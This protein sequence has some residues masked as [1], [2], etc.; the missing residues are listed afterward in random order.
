[1]SKHH[2]K[3]KKRNRSRRNF[4]CEA[5]CAALGTTTFFSSLAQLNLLNAATGLTPKP[6]GDYK[7]MVCIL[8]AGGWDSYNVLVPTNTD[9]YQEYATVR[10]NLALPANSLLP[11]NFTDTQNRTFGLHGAMPEVQQMF[12]S[13]NLS[14]L[15]NVGTMIEPVSTAQFFNDTGNFPL[16]LF[17]HED[18]IQQWQTSVPQDRAAVGW[19]GR[20]ADLLSTLNENN[21]VSMNISLSGSNVFQTGNMATEFSI[22][23]FNG[24]ESIYN[25]GIT[26]ELMPAIKTAAID[27]FVGQGY[28][29]IF[30]HTYTDKIKKAIEG[31]ALFTEATDG[32]T[33]NTS[34]QANQLSRSLQ[35]IARTIKAR[36][37]IGANRQI[38]FVTFGGW[39]HHDELINSQQ[40]KLGLLSAA[41]GSFNDAMTELDLQNE[42]CTFTISDFARTLTSNGNGS[43][44]A[45]GGNQLVMGGGLNGGQ[46]FGAF[47]DQYQGNPLDLEQGT[48]LPTTSTDEFFADLA[49][50]YGV[51]PSNLV[52]VLP[53]IGNFYDVGSGVSPIGIFNA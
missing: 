15:S 25:Y 26:D 28:Q 19:G 3:P 6:P 31:A 20:L 48:F 23:P 50:W 10:S 42:V 35:M 9:S 38:F 8:L 24:A 27:N 40:A 4:L 16:G 18:Q 11:L 30:K 22:H 53:N 45:W 41:L 32:V 33:I 39:D 46:V 13:G 17:S 5:G 7:A 34:F 1:M 37:A 43:D 52:D 49:L 36:N 29:D 21:T 51:D 12:N 44:H 2:H 14:F 47:P